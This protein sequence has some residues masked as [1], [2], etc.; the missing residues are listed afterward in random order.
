MRD[1]AVHPCLA[2]MGDDESHQEIMSKSQPSF[3][4]TPAR[5]DHEIGERL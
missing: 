1:D 3:Y 2:G 5:R 4:S